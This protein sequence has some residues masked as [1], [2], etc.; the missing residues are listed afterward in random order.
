M[1]R[2]YDNK[3]KRWIKNNIYLVPNGD[4]YIL[5][6]TIFKK[7]KKLVLASDDRY[8]YHR[9]IGLTDKNDVLIYEGDIVEAQ[10]SKDETTIVEIA[11]VYQTAS[12]MAFDFKTDTIY[13][14]NEDKCKL[15]KVIGNVFDTPE[16]LNVTDN[17]TIEKV[18]EVE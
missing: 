11:Y 17:A 6:K 5:E 16:L 15:A 1:L 13:T 8:V 18:E 10:I 14:L 2:I 9:N 3:K 12:Y 4:L 7:N